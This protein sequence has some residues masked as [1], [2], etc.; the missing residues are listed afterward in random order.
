MRDKILNNGVILILGHFRAKQS[1]NRIYDNMEEDLYNSVLFATTNKTTVK[2]EFRKIVKRE[3]EKSW[4]ANYPTNLPYYI[5]QEENE[6][7]YFCLNK[8]TGELIH[9]QIVYSVLMN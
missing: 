2:A 9:L 3:K 4:V 5:L 1:D 8:K 7:E 6:D